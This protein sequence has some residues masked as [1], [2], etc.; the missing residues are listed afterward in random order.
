MNKG[1]ALE[2]L[3]EILQFGVALWFISVIPPGRIVPG[4]YFFFFFIV[5][6]LI[7]VLFGNLHLWGEKVKEEQNVVNATRNRSL[8]ALYSKRKYRFAKV[9]YLFF[10][11]LILIFSVA[12]S[13]ESG[14]GYAILALLIVSLIFEFIKRA[15]Y[16]VVLGT[17]NPK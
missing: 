4:K 16:Y 9:V 2:K 13:S 1:I 17:I 8:A 5:G 12:L 6:S 3:F 11:T 15:F 14:L 10:F 7:I